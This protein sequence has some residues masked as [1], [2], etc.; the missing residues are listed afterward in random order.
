MSF[1][2]A[3][4]QYDSMEPPDWDECPICEDLEE[5]ECDFE[6]TR[7]IAASAYADRLIDEA[8]GN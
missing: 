3:Q 8:R 2:L 1:E 5:C 6:G 4:A 7:R